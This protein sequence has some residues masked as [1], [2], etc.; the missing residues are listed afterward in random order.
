MKFLDDC[1]ENKR[2]GNS[3]QLFNR[4]DKNYSGQIVSLKFEKQLL[5]LRTFLIQISN[6]DNSNDRT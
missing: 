6:S 3:Y 2:F 5:Y 1:Q 4:I